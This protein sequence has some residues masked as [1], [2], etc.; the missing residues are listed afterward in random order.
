MEFPKTCVVKR[1]AHFRR[2]RWGDGFAAIANDAAVTPV[3]RLRKNRWSQFALS[4]VALRAGRSVGLATNIWVYIPS[5]G[6]L[7]NDNLDLPPENGIG[8]ASMGRWPYCSSLFRPVGRSRTYFLAAFLAGAFLAA[9]FL[10]GAFLAAA[11]LAGAFLAAAFLAGAFLAAGFFEV[12]DGAFAAAI[13]MD[14]V[15]PRRASRISV[16]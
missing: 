10:A 15:L 1:P 4:R 16:K 13:G 12:T 14:L 8:P 9:A 2:V 3:H 7:S 6:I 11:F 5:A